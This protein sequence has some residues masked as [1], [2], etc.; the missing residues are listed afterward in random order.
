MKRQIL[1][2][3]GIIILLLI[4]SVNY[5]ICIVDGNS[6]RNTL[7]NHDIILV[8]KKNNNIKG[9][10]LIFKLNRDLLIKRCIAL[11]GDT[12]RY[13][14]DSIFVNDILYTIPESGLHEFV[15]EQTEKKKFQRYIEPNINFSLLTDVLDDYDNQKVYMSF[16]F[17]DKVLI[18]HI[19]NQMKLVKS[20]RLTPEQPQN[21]FLIVETKNYFVIGDNILHSYDSRY[22][23]LVPEEKIVGKAVLILFSYQDGKFRWDRFFKRIE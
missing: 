21:N 14:S 15:I 22:F 12:V 16:D 17:T 13:H 10:I 2:F 3:L 4:F 1:F 7:F 8:L 23:G 9:N 6:M 5:R 18:N 11:G 20:E 19:R